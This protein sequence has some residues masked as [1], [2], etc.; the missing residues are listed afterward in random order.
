M[1]LYGALLSPFVR[2]VALVAQEKGIAYELTPFRNR[3]G[4]DPTFLAASPF[5]KIPAIEDDGYMLADST[6]IVSYL[7]AKYPAN[8]LIPADPQLRGKVM[9]FDEFVDTIHCVAG[10]KILFH[11]FVGPK[12]LKVPVNEAIAL[13]GEAEMPRICDYIESVV[14][15][16]GWLLGEFTLADYSVASIL[17]TLTVVGFGPSDAYP[18]TLAWYERVRARPAWQAVAAIEDANAR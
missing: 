1:K 12:I 3:D 6:A 15:D 7:D 8:P 13:E 9:W 18:K 5:N 17:R 2:K 4:L 14:P 10:L 16:E 11:R